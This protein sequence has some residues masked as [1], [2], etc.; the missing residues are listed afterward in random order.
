MFSKL[1]S[2]LHPK[3]NKDVLSI[4]FKIN[5]DK[6]KSFEN[7]LEKEEQETADSEDRKILKEDTFLNPS[8]NLYEKDF[9]DNELQYQTKKL[10]PFPKQNE[11]RP[12]CI[13]R[14]IEDTM[15]GDGGYLTEDL[16]I[17]KY[18]WLQKKTQIVDVK[19]VEYF[20]WIQKEFK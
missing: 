15:S 14:R 13:M 18:I 16:F 17:P 6:V 3:P 19:K 11:L 20:V 7:M 2:N 10:I 9:Q 1:S 12:F 4:V 8:E 5:Q